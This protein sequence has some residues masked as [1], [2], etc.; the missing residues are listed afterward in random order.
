MGRIW[1]FTLKT[2]G[3]R[4]WLIIITW[5]AFK[6][7]IFHFGDPYSLGLSRALICVFLKA[8][9]GGGWGW[10]A[11]AKSDK[12]VT[13]SWAGQFWSFVLSWTQRVHLPAHIQA[14]KDR[15]RSLQPT[16]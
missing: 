7:Q 11:L 9:C 4:T 6:H 3:F 13:D 14:K 15:N 12:G 8:P 2:G 16:K 10:G 5:I 1:I